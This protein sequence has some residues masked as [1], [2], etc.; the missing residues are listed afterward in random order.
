MHRL[1]CRNRSVW[2][3]HEGGCNHATLDN[4]GWLDPKKRGSPKYEVSELA[5][6][7]RTNVMSHAMR[8][9]WVN[10]VFGDVALNA[11]VVV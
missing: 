2:I 11:V 10:G 5:N 9:G 4:C 3:T 8:N 1:W 7:N 6:L